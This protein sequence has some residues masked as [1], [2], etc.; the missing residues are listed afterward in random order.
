M[1]YLFS[2][3]VPILLYTQ[4][5]HMYAE[6]ISIGDGSAIQKHSMSTMTTNPR[7]SRTKTERMNVSVCML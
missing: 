7:T 3:T 4:H 1:M 5:I 2:D 6:E